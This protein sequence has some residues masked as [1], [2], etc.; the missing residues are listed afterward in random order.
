M[1]TPKLDFTRLGQFKYAIINMIEDNGFPLSLPTDFELTLQNEILL[2]KPS[3]KIPLNGRSV[4]VLFNHITAL[5]TG[6]YGERRYMLVWGKLAEQRGH[7]KLHPEAVS[8]W[9]EKVLPFD[10]LCSQAAPQGQKYLERLQR[11]IEV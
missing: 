3:A 6:G 11:Q 5:P 2:K 9:D 10:Q 1:T 4:G 8:E 7:L